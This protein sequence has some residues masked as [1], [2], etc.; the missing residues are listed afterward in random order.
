MPVVGL[1]G[2]CAASRTSGRICSAL[3]LRRLAPCA[4]PAAFTLCTGVVPVPY[5]HIV[6]KSGPQAT[7]EQRTASGV[8]MSDFST[9]LPQA[10]GGLQATDALVVL[11][12]GHRHRGT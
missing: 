8:A 11:V 3:R 2:G 9:P 12:D 7:C 6:N 1:A 10:S 5:R 4:A